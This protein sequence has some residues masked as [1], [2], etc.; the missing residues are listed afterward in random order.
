M[1]KRICRNI[2]QKIMIQIKD[3]V[4]FAAMDPMPLLVIA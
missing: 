1:P 3:K 4:E 2:K